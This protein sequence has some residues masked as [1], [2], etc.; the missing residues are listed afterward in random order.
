[1]RILMTNS[2]LALRGGTEAYVQD[3]AMALVRA[4]HEVTAYSNILGEAALELR[5]ARIHV[6]S[7]LAL[8]PWTPDIVHGHH[9]MEALTALLQFP[10]VP[11]I[12][13][14]HGWTKWLDVPLR[15]PRVL[16][17]VAVDGPTRDALVGRHGIP[18]DRVRLI[19][20]FIDLHR[21]KARG[22][23]P[24]RPR[25]ALVFSHY[26]SEDTY[27]PKVRQACRTRGVALDVMGYGVGRPIRRPEEV[28]GDYDLVFAKG[29]AAL[30]ALVCGCSVIVCDDFGLGP[31]ITTENIKVLRTLEGRYMQWFSATSVDGL[32]RQMDRYN[33]A[34][35]AALTTWLRSTAGADLAA[36]EFVN[37]YGETLAAWARTDVD[38]VA[39]SHAAA[40]HLR[41]VSSYVKEQFVE[42][43]PFAGIA[44]S[45]RNRLTRIPFL[46]P[47]LMRLSAHI[48]ARR[49]N[50]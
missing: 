38:P 3:L 11:A 2:T 19:P 8:A 24:D 18:A 12:F 30:E 35:V 20:N 15:H 26:A 10:A 47:V 21:F 41:W 17:H 27:V 39:E 1:M 40:A 16:N 45:L 43:D 42:R 31:M 46:A 44:V 34:D 5:A 7:D 50:H 23:L 36:D 32:L 29:R 14:S 28:L 9:N 37:L 6:V 22:L 33:P 13:V 25:R 4:G 49:S 48:R